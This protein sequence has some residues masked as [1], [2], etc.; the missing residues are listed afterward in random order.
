[1]GFGDAAVRRRWG[2]RVRGLNQRTDAMPTHKDLKRLVRQRMQKTGESYT[3]ARAQLTKIKFVSMSSAPTTPLRVLERD[4]AKVAGMSDE[5]VKAKTGCTWKKWVGALDYKKAYEWPHG[6][7][8]AYLHEEFEVPGWWAQMITVGYER[9]RGLRDRGQRRDGA[10]EANKS[11]T[12]AVPLAT[13]FDAFAVAR[14]RSRWLK[15]AKYTMRKATPHKS[16]RILWEDETPVE[17]FFLSKGAGKSS[18]AIQH[19]KLASKDAAARVKAFWGER[20]ESLE[21]ILAK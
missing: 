2:M 8:V 1:M 3:A 6:K 19:R 16:V 5:A 15:G 7:I 4:Y 14:Q 11:K 10:Y 17:V 21:E 12:F 9:I 13:L 20:L 18:A